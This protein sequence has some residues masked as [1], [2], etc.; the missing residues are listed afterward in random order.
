MLLKV[1]F[2]DF[3]LSSLYRVSPLHLKWGIDTVHKIA[4]LSLVLSYVSSSLR[5]YAL[6]LIV[7]YVM[8]A[9]RYVWVCL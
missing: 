6:M 7:E 8:N 3:L 1:S 9:A 5:T 4:Q 2:V